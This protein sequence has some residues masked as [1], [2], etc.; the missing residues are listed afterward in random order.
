MFAIRG[1]FSGMFLFYL[2]VVTPSSPS[3]MRLVGVECVCSFKKLW[4]GL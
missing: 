4:Q 1:L 3:I 2:E